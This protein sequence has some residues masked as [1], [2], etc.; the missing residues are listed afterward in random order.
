[1][2]DHNT[3]VRP[4]WPS[5]NDIDALKKAHWR[6]TPIRQ[7]VLKV[8]SRCNLA[9]DYCYVYQMADQTWRDRPLVMSPE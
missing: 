8:Y 3:G 6:P 9:C 5:H 4:E 7:F 2:K 1:M